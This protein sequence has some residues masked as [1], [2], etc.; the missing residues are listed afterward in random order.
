[1]PVHTVIAGL[2][3]RAITRASLRQTFGEALAGRL[4]P[5][6]F[7]DLDRPLVER[8]LAREREARR[9]GPLAESILRDLGVVA[10]RP[11]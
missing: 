2:G 1:V 9:S 8:A 3:G 11:V 10:A 7:L 4:E 6:S 5:L